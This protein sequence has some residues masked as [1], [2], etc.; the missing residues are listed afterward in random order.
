MHPRVTAPGTAQIPQ[1]KG[2]NATS[3]WERFE[4]MVDEFEPKRNV[5][6]QL[7]SQIRT[8]EDYLPM[9]TTDRFI[10]NPAE[11]TGPRGLFF[12]RPS[13]SSPVS[14]MWIVWSAPMLT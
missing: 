4:E 7:R 12:V 3:F 1:F 6:Y 2:D 8:L 5:E 10:L 14:T 11:C 13:S 9:D